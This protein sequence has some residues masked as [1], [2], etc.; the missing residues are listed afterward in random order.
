MPIFIR[1]LTTSN[2]VL[3]MYLGLCSFF[4]VSKKLGPT[5]SMRAA[6]TLVMTIA[7]S[8]TWLISYYVLIPFGV[9][10]MYIVMYILVIASLVQMIEMTI[11]RMNATLYNAL[12][13]YLPLITVNCAIL[14]IAFVNTRESYTILQSI[15]NGVGAGIGYSIAIILLSSIRE[16]LEM[17]D[18]PKSMRGFPIAFLIAAI[19]AFIF[20]FAFEGVV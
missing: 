16:K 3:V 12:G 7:S 4:G 5:I 13:I 6:V 18:L 20:V 10:Y 9:E 17:A 14:A 19:L 8:A 2:V 11:K 15:V 1:M